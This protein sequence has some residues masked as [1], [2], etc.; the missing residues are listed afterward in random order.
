MRKFETHSSREVTTSRPDGSR[1]G[2]VTR[3]QKEKG[4]CSDYCPERSSDALSEDMDA[5]ADLKGW[6]SGTNTLISF[7]S[8]PPIRTS[9]S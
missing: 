5:Q 2:T 3:T 6:V 1:K 7:F 4:L 8:L 9:P